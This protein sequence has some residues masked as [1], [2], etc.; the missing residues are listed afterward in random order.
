MRRPTFVAATLLLLLVSVLA[1]AQTSQ[2]FT[3]TYNFQGTLNVACCSSFS[4]GFTPVIPD[5]SFNAPGSAINITS[6]AVSAVGSV[7]SPDL[8]G[9]A[10]L[11]WEVFIGPQSFGL[12]VVEI[13]GTTTDPGTYSSSAPTQL[14]FAEITPLQSGSYLFSGLYSFGAGTLITDTPIQNL[15]G[16]STATMDV[17]QGFYVQVF[18]WSGAQ[19]ANIDFSSITVA[20]AG[21]LV[22]FHVTTTSVPSAQVDVPYDSG[23]ST[24]VGGVPFASSQI[25][26]NPY[27]WTITN[28]PPGL[29]INSYTGAIYGLPIIDG[30]F[31]FK[32][33]A[34]DSTAATSPPQGLAMAIQPSPYK[35]RCTAAEKEYDTLLGKDLMNRGKYLSRSGFV[36]SKAFPE[37]APICLTATAFGWIDTVIGVV[38][39]VEAALDPPDTNYTIIAQPTPLA[40][41]LP[42]ADPSW[43]PAQLAAYNSLKNVILTEEQLAGLVQASITS[44]NRAEGAYEAGNTY[45]EQQQ[46][47]ALN[48]YNYLEAFDLQLLLAESAQAKA[49]YSTSGFPDF[50]VSTDDANQFSLGILANGLDPTTQQ[51]LTSLG[52]DSDELALVTKVWSSF[53]PANISGD[54]LQALDLSPDAATIQQLA[55]SFFTKFSAF[56]PKLQQ[57]TSTGAFELLASFTL[58]TSSDGLH[59]GT[60]DLSVSLGTF[61]FTI[62]AESFKLSSKGYCQ[63]SGATWQAVIK[64]A[65]RGYTLQIDGLGPSIVA[66][67]PVT[68]LVGN[69]EGSATISLSN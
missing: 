8:L 5:E 47:A 1:G 46:V 68:V 26:G 3:R 23:P 40:L 32:I 38:L 15:K 45:W 27:L 66:P 62:P 36:C 64:P 57:T 30:S 31:L 33:T 53:N 48:R 7:N 17:S 50:T 12:P 52:L 10:G 41:A 29:D 24:A 35:S 9:N 16:A 54:F 25:G 60:D 34:I 58:G 44:I 14:R 37:I 51:Q 28:P 43:T 13:S 63:S 69:D 11:D 55:G 67:V 19:G 56:A 42:S 65:T 39:R 21:N 2:T 59:C 6:I 61:A 49:A 22:P 18:I 4:Y 20:I